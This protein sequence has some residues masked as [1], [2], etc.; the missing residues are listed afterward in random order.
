MGQEDNNREKEINLV[1]NICVAEWEAVGEHML[2]M[3]MLFHL[4][5]PITYF[6]AGQR[7]SCESDKVP[8]GSKDPFPLVDAEVRLL[9]RFNFEPEMTTSII[10]FLILRF[11]SAPIYPK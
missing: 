5:L 1:R 4:K 6:P 9:Y 3:N 11:H 2:N 10:C 8:D 7:Q